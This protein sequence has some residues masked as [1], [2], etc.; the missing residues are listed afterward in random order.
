MGKINEPTREFIQKLTNK[1]PI[2]IGKNYD[3]L[4]D[5]E[6]FSVIGGKFSKI[7]NFK[8][9]LFTLSSKILYGVDVQVGKLLGNF[10]RLDEK[11]YQFSLSLDYLYNK[12]YLYERRDLKKGYG[13]GFSF[14]LDLTLNLLENLLLNISFQDFYGK[15]YWKNIP[16]TVADATTDREYYDEYGN[17]VYRPLIQGYEGYKDYIQDIPLK[18]RFLMEYS[19]NPFKLNL[20]FN[21]LKNYYFYHIK[22][23]YPLF[24][25]RNFSFINSPYYK[26][27]MEIPSEIGLIFSGDNTSIYCVSFYFYQVL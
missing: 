6:G 13:L 19:I 23:S 12:N 26:Y 14:D 1:E 21:F 25:S 20:N 11:S 5:L 10:R 17:I 24:F 16:Y 18:I 15:I 3:I 9:I 2:T 7:H 27:Y 8:N 4:F 22:I